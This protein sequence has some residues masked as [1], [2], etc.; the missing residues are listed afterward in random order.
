MRKRR[1]DAATLSEIQPESALPPPG[2]P[3]RVLRILAYILLAG[4]FL[5]PL[6]V[7]LDGHD[8]F[9]LPKQLVLYAV[10]IIALAVTA[11]AL[12]LEKV[13]LDRN[14]RLLAKFAAGGLAWALVTVVLSTN[15]TL[16]VEAFVWAAALTA[17]FFVAAISF[18]DVRV[19]VV[20]I[21]VL[22]P[23]V[24]NAVILT[25]QTFDVWNPWVFPTSTSTRAT[26]NALLGNP[27]DVGGYLAFPLLFACALMLYAKRWR[28]LYAAVVIV[29]GLALL[30]TQTITAIGSFAIAFAV[31]GIRWNP[32]TGTAVAAAGA[33]LLL[34]GSLLYDP[35]QVRLLYLAGAVERGEWGRVVS[36]RLVPYATAWQMF[37]DHP[38]TGVGP[39]A[40]K[41]HYL[42]YVFKVETASPT[43]A[44]LSG[45][46]RVNFHQAHNDHLQ[47]LA[48]T[49]VLGY[50][51]VLAAIFYVATVWRR[52]PRSDDERVT[53]ARA[54]ALPL[55][56]LLLLV[57]V[58]Q[59]V[60]QLAA[61]AYACI[62]LGGA[63][64]AWSK[65]DVA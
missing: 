35:L 25:L 19:E 40:F 47:L 15:R 53:V 16:S 10:A 42:P 63:C 5:T 24:V 50:L 12:V 20:A 54:L 61:P 45:T 38:V 22:V 1:H 65:R 18:R 52:T 49:G 9:R 60:L 29:L 62:L 56:V 31:M 36:G 30:M 4:A 2:A 11:I 33:I 37:L 23:A 46:Q 55:C 8:H 59:F 51:A 28:L 48:E 41:F 58:A 17:V 7:S 21:A 26:H 57:M 27:D 64:L 43:L 44:K 39:G 13:Q 6:V 32:R 34:A 3:P 14:G